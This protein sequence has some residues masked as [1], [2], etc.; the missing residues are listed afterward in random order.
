MFASRPEDMRKLYV[1]LI[2]LL[3]AAAPFISVT[4]AAAD[5]TFTNTGFRNIPSGGHDVI[6]AFR[7]H[8]GA[9]LSYD[10]TVMMPTGNF[11]VLLL[12]ESNY[13]RYRDGQS[14]DFNTDGS[15]L[16]VA[17]SVSDTLS[18]PSDVVFYL[19]VD[20]SAVPAGGSSPT[21]QIRVFFAVNETNTTP[22]LVAAADIILIIVIV[23]IVAI[24]IIIV[25]VLLLR[26]KSTR[27]P[28]PAQM[29]PAMGTAYAPTPGTPPQGAKEKVEGMKSCPN[30]GFYMPEDARFCPRCGRAM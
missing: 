22:L 12:N 7:T 10:V 8:A 19:V 6:T 29:P 3:V 18:L 26:K 15:R 14:F 28:P 17:S 4:A 5:S 2:V 21:G 27:A 30:C 11:D 16:N 9:S 13:F 24:A 23:A 1:A 25:V 20:N